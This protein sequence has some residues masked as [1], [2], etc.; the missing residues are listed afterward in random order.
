MFRELQVYRSFLIACAG[1]CLDGRGS[2]CGEGECP[3]GAGVSYSQGHHIEG[4]GS[5]SRS[6][7]HCVVHS[8]HDLPPEEGRNS[9]GS[10]EFLLTTTMGPMSCF[11]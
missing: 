1:M 5:H 10:A 7:V 11:S 9:P 3:R 6:G 2:I 8:F 4:C